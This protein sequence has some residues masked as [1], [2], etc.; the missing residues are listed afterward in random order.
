MTSKDVGTL[1]TRLSWEDEGSTKSLKGF[2]D[3]L[4]G[5]RTEMNAAKSGGQDYTKSLKGLSEQSDIL[6][7]QFKTQKEQVSELKKRYEESKAIKGEDAEQTKNLSNQYNNAVAAMNRTENQ[8]ALVTSAIEKQINPWKRLGENMTDAGDKMQEFGK[9]MTDFGK[10]YSMRVTAP[11][12]ASGAAV[13][14][15]AS[16]YES[17]FA[18]VRKTVNMSET[19]FESLSDSIRNMAKE[20][21]AAA[22]EIALVAEAAGQLGIKNEAIEGFTRTMIDLGV[23]TNMSSDEAATALARFANITQMSQKDFDR[24]G[25]VVVELGNNFATTEREI[26]DMSLRL[27]GAGAQ[28]GMSESD[29]LALATALSSVGIEAEMGG[30]AISRVMVN[31]QVATST[32]FTKV[33]GLLD[34]TGLSLRDLQMMASHSGKAFGHLAE[35]LGMTKKEFTNLVNAGVDLEGFSKVAGMTGEQFKQA[36]EKDAIG[37]LGA[38]VNGL[39]NAEEAGESAINMLQEMG[40]TEIRLRDSLLRA[41]GASELFA[42]SVDLASGA[43]AENNALTKEAEERYKTTASQMTILWN[44]AKDVAITLGNALI[45]AVMDAID[46]AAPLIRQIE[47]GAKAFSEMDEGQQRTILTMLGLVA[48][49]GPASIILGQLTTGIGGVLK[50]GGSLAGLLGKTGGAGLIGRIGMMGLGAT[51]VGLAVAGVGALAWGILEL[52]KANDESIFRVQESIEKRKEEIDSLDGLI[53][54]YETLQK[55]NK[56]SSDEML[57]YMDIMSELK[58]A[59]AEESIKKLTDEQAALLEKSGLTNEQMEEFLTLNGKIIEK[60]PEA[61]KAISDQGNAYAGVLDELK[62]LNNLERQRLTDETGKAITDELDKQERNLKKQETSQKELDRLEKVRKQ[63]L[64]DMVA[65]NGKIMDKKVEIAKLE[66]DSMNLSQDELVVVLDKL[67]VMRDELGELEKINA[68]HEVSM[69]NVE[70]TLK[71]EKE[72]LANVGKKLEAFDKLKD[73]YAQMILFEQGIVSEKGKAV[74][75]LI[76]EQIKLNENRDALERMHKEG[77][78]VGA[79][80]EEQN[81]LLNEQQGKINNATKSLEAMNEIAGKKIYKDLSIIPSPDIAS[82]NR[83]IGE[84]VDKYVSVNIGY[85]DGPRPIGYATGT[86]YH[87]GGPFIAGE[88]GFELGR[89]GNQWE[90]LN[91]GMYNRPAGFEV[92]THDESKDILRALNRMPAYAK[93][94]NPTGESSRVVSRLNDQQQ[95]TPMVVI[96]NFIVDAKNIKEYNDVVEIMKRL[97]QVANAFGLNVT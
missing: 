38:F 15:A 50:V 19:E 27:A 42:K 23:S 2:R 30:S 72:S 95:Q 54:S 83:Q 68:S 75:K 14:K 92:F 35:D 81:S 97:P 21:P 26:V 20:I 4:K 36:F 47:S 28:V 80:Y 67:G 13:F 94:A 91:L 22:T 70:K 8:L 57:R 56:L 89:L 44:K 64:E 59:K 52:N 76:D 40:I 62:K 5:L 58:D 18:G 96:E 17:A 74:D 34:H 60:A 12:V 6:T 45:P 78:L 10:S 7:R 79:A 3:D 85:N 48:A 43:W 25:S 73:D 86:D 88:E 71:D 37:A 55:K 24:L 33:Q 61:A 9:G 31:M 41:G 77:Q 93:G 32:G 46:A 29:I 39:G 49:V 82:L 16:D 65:N 84:R 53:A 11:I 63:T 51:P 66:T 87:P 69:K 1:R 90:M